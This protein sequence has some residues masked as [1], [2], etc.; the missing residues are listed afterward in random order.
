M[1]RRRGFRRGG[2]VTLS[3][4]TT[5]TKTAPRPDSSTA[6]VAREREQPRQR[7]SRRERWQWSY[8]GG[9]RWRKFG[10]AAQHK[11]VTARQAQTIDLLDAGSSDMQN[12]APR[13]EGGSPGDFAYC[14]TSVKKV[15]RLRLACS[16]VLLLG[17]F[18]KYPTPAATVVTP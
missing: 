14:L 10:L 15:D 4:N 2:R 13:S 17:C 12:V 16:H 11:Y 6:P 8:H 18:P 5:P 7:W 9:C 3:L 1:W